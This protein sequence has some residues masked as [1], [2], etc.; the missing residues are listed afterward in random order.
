MD[1]STYNGAWFSF[2]VGDLSLCPKVILNLQDPGTRNLR[3]HGQW[4]YELRKEPNGDWIDAREDCFSYAGGFLV[5]IMNQHDQDF[6]MNFLKEEKVHVPIWIGIN[7]RG[8]EEHFHWDSGTLDYHIYLLYDCL[9][10]GNINLYIVTRTCGVWP[11]K[12]L[13]FFFKI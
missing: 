11:S 3:Q 4:C 2:L 7:D 13:E 8:H 5:Q 6:I 12:C 1:K 10:W 9:F